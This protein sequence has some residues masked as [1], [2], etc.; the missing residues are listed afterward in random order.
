MGVGEAHEPC[1]NAMRDVRAE[2]RDITY[3]T[4]QLFP[5]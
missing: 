3:S 5:V 1:A 4:L 2:R